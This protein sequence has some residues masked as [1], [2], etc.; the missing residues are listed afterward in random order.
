MLGIHTP[1]L[2]LEKE[3][4]LALLW[5][6]EKDLKGETLSIEEI[7]GW[8]QTFLAIH[9]E[10]FELVEH[11][12][13]HPE[14]WKPF[15]LL[16]QKAHMDCP[17]PSAE[18]GYEVVATRAELQVARRNLRQAAWSYTTKRRGYHYAAKEFPETDHNIITHLLHDHVYAK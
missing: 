17:I 5:K 18:Y 16:A 4:V 13:Q 11:Y 2:D 12:A 3:N 9:E 15:L 10:F 8:C 1:K 7:H 6:A 14:P